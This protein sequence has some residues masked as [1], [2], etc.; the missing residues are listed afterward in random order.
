MVVGLTVIACVISVVFHEY[1]VAA[2]EVN[3]AD[4]P[5][6]IEL[7]PDILQVG[8]AVIVIVSLQ[9]VVTPVPEVIDI[10]IVNEPEEAGII[11]TV[12][13]WEPPLIDALP[14]TDHVKVGLAAFVT[15]A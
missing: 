10:L 4:C 13:P 5:L 8:F 14:L 2:S 9:F 1:E 12:E 11:V 6:Q 15:A 3:V 7:L